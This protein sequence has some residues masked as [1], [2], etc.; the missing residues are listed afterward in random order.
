MGGNPS[1]GSSDSYALYLAPY[2]AD[3]DIRNNILVNNRSNSGSTGNNYALYFQESALSTS[4]LTLDYNDYYTPGNGGVLAYVNGASQAILPLVAD[5]DAHSLN[6]DPVFA[7]LGGATAASFLPSAKTLDAVTGTGITTDY[8]G[9]TRSLVYPAMGA[10]EFDVSPC[11]NPTNGGIIAGNQSGC[12]PFDANEI[13]SS[14]LPAGNTGSLVYQWQRSTDSITFGSIDGATLET[15]DPELLESTTWYKRLSRVAC[16][17]NW[18]GAAE[19]NM[20]KIEVNSVPDKPAITLTGNTFSSNSENGNQWYLEGV[21]I[22][23]ATGK[24]YTSVADGNYTVIV[25]LNGCSS[26][27]SDSKLFLPA[28]VNDL[29]VS[30]SFDV[31]PNPSRGKF[32]IKVTSAKPVELTIELLSNIGVPV[33]KQEKASIN[34][35]GIIPVYPGVL[36]N[37]VYFV[38]LRNSETMMT[39]KIVIMK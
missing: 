31:Y 16:M 14:E 3:R 7:N 37:G 23:G 38:T 20:V 34:G 25:T 27:T 13:T 1:S 30:Q 22:E 9:V 29:D 36:P 10:W 11:G 21:A 12:S 33:W 26:A 6:I 8:A 35:T 2:T 17:S 5:Q 32:T 24:E 15:Y 18:T 19:T 39:R 4:N 28:T